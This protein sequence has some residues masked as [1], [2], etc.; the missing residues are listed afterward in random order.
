[1]SQSA[2]NQSAIIENENNSNIVMESQAAMTGEGERM[3]IEDML[4]AEAG[5]ETPTQDEVEGSMDMEED[6]RGDDQGGDG[7]AAAGGN[8]AELISDGG[9]AGQQSVVMDAHSDEV[10]VGIGA[11]GDALLEPQDGPEPQSPPPEEAGEQEEAAEAMEVEETEPEPCEPSEEGQRE[12]VCD[13]GQ[14]EAEENADASQETAEGGI[15]EEEPSTPVSAEK[16]EADESALGNQEAPEMVP[17]GDDQLEKEA[18]T[19][20]AEGDLA[21]AQNVENADIQEV[22]QDEQAEAEQDNVALAQCQAEGVEASVSAEDEDRLLAE[23]NSQSQEA[24]QD[25]ITISDVQEITEDHQ[26]DVAD[27]P[28]VA[29]AEP[30]TADATEVDEGQPADVS[31]VTTNL[32]EVVADEPEASEDQPEVM[33]EQPEAAKETPEETDDAAEVVQDAPETVTDAPEAAGDDVKIVPEVVEGD[34]QIDAAAEFVEDGPEN[35]VDSAAGDCDLPEAGEDVQQKAADDEEKAQ[36]VVDIEDEPELTEQSNGQPAAADSVADVQEP[37]SEAGSKEVGEGGD[38]SIVE[39]PEKHLDQM[40]G[41]DSA[42]V[43][44]TTEKPAEVAPA[45]DEGN[46]ESKPAD[47]SEKPEEDG[48]A[49]ALDAEG[50][51]ASDATIEEG[52]DIEDEPMLQVM[53]V[54]SGAEA[55]NELMAE[56]DVEDLTTDDTKKDSADAPEAMETDAAGEAAT[57]EASEAGDKNMAEDGA[58]KPKSSETDVPAVQAPPDDDDDDVVVLDDDD[59]TTPQ[60]KKE[61]AEKELFNSNNDMGIQIESV[62]GGADELHELAEQQPVKQVGAYSFCWG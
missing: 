22:D 11:A 43:Q 35:K 10:A 41:M 23:D 45:E 3:N 42:E 50:D 37:T 4:A 1:M 30:D 48:L 31:E 53:D 59:E 7:S 47:D 38:V 52:R 27:A 19:E 61:A 40:E 57:V 12:Q 54:K 25:G 18:T 58:G 49:Q 33:N 62:S 17:D 6:G 2:E 60:V 36:E 32:P 39:A 55:E 21:A 26:P 15:L 34:S 44:D 5:P 51:R 46:A 8:E 13:P 16:E 24:V 56:Q 14:V 29:E 9:D 28:E 20:E